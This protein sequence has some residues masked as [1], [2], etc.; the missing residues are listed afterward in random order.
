MR[1]AKD[2][3]KE[4][5]ASKTVLRELHEIL[6]HPLGTD[7]YF[8]ELLMRRTDYYELFAKILMHIRLG[9][10]P[11]LPKDVEYNESVQLFDEL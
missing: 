8:T 7:G 6:Q 4:L 2:S 3:I 11:E 1:V 5:G 10:E 9:R